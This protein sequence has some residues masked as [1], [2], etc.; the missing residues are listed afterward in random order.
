MCHYVSQKAF[1]PESKMNAAAHPSPFTATAISALS[2]SVILVVKEVWNQALL[3]TLSTIW[4]SS[5]LLIE[6]CGA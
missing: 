4:L 1:V 6:L 3:F 2:D 5:P